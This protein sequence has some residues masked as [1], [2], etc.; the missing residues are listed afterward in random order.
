MIFQSFGGILVIKYVK[1]REKSVFHREYTQNI[2]IP[3]SRA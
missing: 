3:T 1:N 2:N